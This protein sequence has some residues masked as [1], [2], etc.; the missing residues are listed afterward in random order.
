M[1]E[2]SKRLAEVRLPDKCTNFGGPLRHAGSFGGLGRGAG[3]A[4]EWRAIAL[5]ALER[6]PSV[7]KFTLFL[8]QFNKGDPIEVYVAGGHKIAGEFILVDELGVLQINVKTETS[9]RALQVYL[10]DLVAVSR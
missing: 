7:A 3:R 1:T 4:V 5:D 6:R 2:R 10:D 8:G 9:S